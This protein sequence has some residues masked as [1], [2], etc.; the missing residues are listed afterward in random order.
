VDVTGNTHRTEFCIDKLYDPTGPGGR[1]GLVEVRG[2]EMPPAARMSLVQQLLLRALVAGFWE[3]PYERRLIHWGTRLADDC[4][5]PHHVERDFSEALEELRG[6]GFAFDPGWFAPHV[7]F[8]FPTIGHIA[9]RDMQLELRNALEPWHVL[10]E[11]VAAGG[12]TRYVD[13]ARAERAGIDGRR[14]T[15]P[16][17][18]SA[19]RC[20]APAR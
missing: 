4:M 19:R 1:R 14:G 16:D 11:E 6:L 3:R 5:L 10:G 2:F 13:G 20:G 12:T 17:A 7:E 18:L 8:R 15:G 9:V